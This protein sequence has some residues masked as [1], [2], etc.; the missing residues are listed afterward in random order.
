M[1]DSDK[2]MRIKY[3]NLSLGFFILFFVSM[4]VFI[5]SLRSNY[6]KMVG[7]RNA[8]Y[9]ADQNNGD[10]KKAL[11]NLRD[12]VTTHMNTDLTSG[13][14]SVYP[15]I[16]L[17][18]TYQRLVQSQLGAQSNNTQLYT[19][20][21]NFCQTQIPSG[22]SGRYRIPCVENYINTH[23]LTKINIDP[24]LYE[25]AFSTPSFSYDLAGLSMITTIILGSLSLFYLL[26]FL[27]RI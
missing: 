10:V 17:E 16:Q 3:K 22:F 9:S 14:N 11:T 8:L 5:Y 18:Y 1:A 23:S 15:P 12:Y 13:S 21:E 27:T 19:D 6:S 4:C 7:L 20:A 25:F 26:S 24:S 2:T